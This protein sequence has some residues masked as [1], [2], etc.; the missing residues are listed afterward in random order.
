VCRG[1]RAVRLA[2]HDGMDACFHPSE[3]RIQLPSEY[4]DNAELS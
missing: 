1:L 2:Y 3:I 4:K